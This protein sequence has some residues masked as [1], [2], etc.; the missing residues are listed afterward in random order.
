MVSKTVLREVQVHVRVT[1]EAAE[2]RPCGRDSPWPEQ[3]SL[4]PLHPQHLLPGS[5]DT[6]G[7]GEN[8]LWTPGPP[9]AKQPQELRAHGPTI[10]SFVL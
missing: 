5:G 2:S 3:C 1:W 6:R 8:Q 4:L 7:S 10:I 9:V